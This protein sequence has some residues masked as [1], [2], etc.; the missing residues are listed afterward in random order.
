MNTLTTRYIAD[1]NSSDYE[2]NRYGAANFQG[3]VSV[4]ELMVASASFSHWKGVS[5]IIFDSISDK[6]SSSG[7][8]VYCFIV[9]PCWKKNTRLV[10]HFA[11]SKALQKDYNVGLLNF[12]FEKEVISSDEVIFYGV[13]KLTS[14]NCT[15]VF[16]LL[17][18]YENGIL[19]SSSE[20]E[21]KL[22]EIL[23][24]ELM[25]LIDTKN[26][27]ASYSFNIVKAVNLI[28]SEGEKALYPYAWEDTGEYHLDIFECEN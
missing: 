16:N 26:T 28:I 13:V 8:D 9:S 24:E 18:I 19:F 14:E 2:F 25:K 15:S 21:S 4:T 1:I 20:P 11:L 27:R 12:E 5:D 10:R 17:S 23:V 22:F 7:K 6:F 3:E